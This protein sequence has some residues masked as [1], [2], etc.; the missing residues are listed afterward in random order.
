MDISFFDGN[1]YQTELERGSY[2]SQ[3]GTV[4]LGNGLGDFKTVLPKESGFQ[5]NCDSRLIKFLITPTG[6]ILIIGCSG[7]RLKFQKLE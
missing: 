5:T 2:T 6:K 1:N 4:L 3:Q 7:E